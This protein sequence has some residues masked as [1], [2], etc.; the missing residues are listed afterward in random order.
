MWSFPGKRQKNGSTKTMKD[1]S[2]HGG[3][4]QD[5]SNA[6][7]QGEGIWLIIGTNTTAMQLAI[8]G[9]SVSY[10]K[11]WNMTIQTH[12][13][14]GSTAPSGSGFPHIEASRSYSLTHTHTHQIRKDSSGRVI[15][16]LQRQQTTLAT[17]TRYPAGFEPALSASERPQTHTLNHA[18][19]HLASSSNTQI[20][21]DM[22][23]TAN[24]TSRTVRQDACTHKLRF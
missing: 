20:K 17:N 2:N 22:R 19:G 11:G 1:Q 4:I 6:L 9:G 5:K 24:V 14:N 23:S 13:V 7:G 21:M 3:K 8:N 18:A 10:N 16:P 12:R 15:S